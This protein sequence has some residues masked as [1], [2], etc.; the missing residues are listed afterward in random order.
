MTPNVSLRT[1]HDDGP[2]PLAG[3]SSHDSPSGPS[4]S[5]Y[6]GV[7]VTTMTITPDPPDGARPD[8]LLVELAGRRR[9]APD[10]LTVSM[11]RGTRS[12][13][14]SDLRLTNPG[15]DITREGRRG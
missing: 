12:L 2:D 4:W 6:P 9:V 7:T 14:F 3:G 10:E 15:S 11:P 8:G 5:A 13:V 1:E